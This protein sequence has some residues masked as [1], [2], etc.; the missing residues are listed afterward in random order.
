MPELT[1]Q[2][3]ELVMNDIRKQ[4]VN[5]SHLLDELVDH[6]C[7]DIE[8]EMDK[9]LAFSDAYNLVKQRTGPRRF[10]EIQKETLYAVDS[11]YRTMKN[12]MKIS[13]IAGTIMF[14]VA[15]LFKIQHWPG[16]AVMMTLG[17]FILA[18][19]FLPSALNVL[20]KETHN[21]KRLFLFISIFLTGFFFIAGTL[22]KVQHWPMAGIIL[23]LSAASAVFMLLP[24]VIGMILKLEENRTKQSIFIIALAGAIFYILGMLFKI[25]HWPLATILMVSGMFMIGFIALPWYTVAT[26]KNEEKID[27]RFIFYIVA[28][29][30]IIVPGALINLNMQG[31]YEAGF[32]YSQER[33]QS[34]HKYLY[35]KNSVMLSSR[36]DSAAMRKA[37]M[38][39]KET[40]TLLGNIDE[41]M[42]A[43]VLKSE[44]ETGNPSITEGKLEN[45]QDGL[46]IRYNQLSNPFQTFAASEFLVPGNE[47]RIKLE[48]A[49]TDYSKFITASFPDQGSLTKLLDPALYLPRSADV[50]VSMLSCL[51]S[52]ELLRNSVLTVESSTLNSIISA[53]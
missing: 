15:A 44:G 18:F 32:Y 1:I 48:Q 43:M 35:E 33:Q 46:N 42:K 3:I 30:A 22:F 51:H 21:S 36:T 38:V 52:L 40:L 9:G 29:L 34:L 39:Q 25:Q 27:P 16:A 26:W 45:F 13:G 8:N 17:A 11:K 20:W 7:C 5:F 4:D 50:Q 28:C 53:R 6:V 14:G 12:T 19:V 10:S 31:S 47:K 37:G 23:T 41:L 49:M 2:N 24:S